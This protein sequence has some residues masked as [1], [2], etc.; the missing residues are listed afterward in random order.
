MFD[1]NKLGDLS[2]MASQ[3]K[4]IQKNQERLQNE[5]IELLKKISGQLEEVLSMLKREEQQIYGKSSFNSSNSF[6]V[7]EYSTYC[8]NCKKKVFA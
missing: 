7:V 5:Q 3:A 8:A 1:F 2:K 4:E 6:T